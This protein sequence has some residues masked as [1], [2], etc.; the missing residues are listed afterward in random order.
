[1][2]DTNAISRCPKRIE[3]GGIIGTVDIGECLFQCAAFQDWQ[4]I[5]KAP[6]GITLAEGICKEYKTKVIARQFQ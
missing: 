5:Q 3:E 4:I 1:M 6:D 2:M